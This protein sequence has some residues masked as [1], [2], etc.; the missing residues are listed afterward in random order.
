MRTPATACWEAPI[1]NKYSD[2]DDDSEPSIGSHL[3]MT[4]TSTPQARF[5]YWKGM[6]PSELLDDSTHLV[7][8]IQELPY[9][10]GRP[11][12]SITEGE[13]T[14]Y[15]LTTAPALVSTRR[16][17]KSTWLQSMTMMKMTNLETNTTMN[18]LR[19]SPPMRTRRTPLKTKTR[20]VGGCAGKKRQA[21]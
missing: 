16:S 11:L 2:S 8:Y 12:A 6:E 9:E 4:I 21:C 1:F 15:W 18:Y 19:T 5:V 7:A 3:D 10:E 17:A 20:R 14:P 13:A